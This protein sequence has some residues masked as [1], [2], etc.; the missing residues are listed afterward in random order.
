M[1]F[2]RNHSALGTDQQEPWA[3]GEPYESICRRWIELRYQF[4]PYI[5]TAAWQAAETGLPMMRPLALAFPEDLRTYSRDDEFLLGDALLAA[6]VGYPGQTQRR[7]YLP[8]GPW[9]DFWTG[10]PRS[11]EVS[12]DAPLERMPLFVRAGSVLPMGPVMQHTGEWPPE[13]LQLNVYP[14]DGESW[15]YEDDGHSLSYEKGEVRLTRFVA[16]V[17]GDDLT[18][19]RLVEGPFDP[20]YA[21]FEITVY[22]VETAPQQVLLDGQPVRATHNAE[23]GVVQL[24][25]GPW[26]ELRVVWSGDSEGARQ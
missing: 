2:F 19:R 17:A 15:L 13:V 7:V 6:P 14:G 1:P 12:V 3:F 23:Q 9:Y 18:L 11:G 16:R 8:G 5:Y 20:G 24:A 21:W 4:L 22:G 26:S 10:R 25:A